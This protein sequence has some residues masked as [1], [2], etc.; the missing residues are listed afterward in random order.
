MLLALAFPERPDKIPVVLLVEDHRDTRAMY[1]EFLRGAFEV[2]EAADGEQAL[3]VLR[4]R[5]PDLVVTDLSLPV[6]DGFQLILRI[7]QE[8]SLRDLPVISLSG[9]GGHAHDERARQAG[10]DRI[11]QKPCLPDALAE[12][13]SDLLRERTGRSRRT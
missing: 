4:T 9:F 1:S 10:C 13:V 7:R 2:L 3:A 6:L 11:L 12:A 8:P 5:V